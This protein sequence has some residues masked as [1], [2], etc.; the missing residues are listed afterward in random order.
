MTEESKIRIPR[1][2]LMERTWLKEIRLK[3][4]LTQE[5]VADLL[6]DYSRSGYTN[7]ERGERRP[8]P[9]I[10]QVIARILQLDE[11]YGV[12]WSRLLLDG[13]GTTETR[14][15]RNIELQCNRETAPQDESTIETQSHG[16]TESRNH[17]DGI[18]DGGEENG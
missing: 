5:Q 9:E 10:A 12:H 16:A 4:G 3:E 6:G 7:I 8:S 18:T 11:K 13:D 17:G 14:N 15:N 1:M 2:Q